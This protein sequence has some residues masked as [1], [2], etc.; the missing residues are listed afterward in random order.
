LILLAVNSSLL[1]LAISTK[2][3]AGQLMV[4]MIAYGYV[5]ILYFSKKKNSFSLDLFVDGEWMLACISI[6]MISR[7]G[8]T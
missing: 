7:I 8:L 3:M 2:G 5:Y 1:P 6:I 4:G